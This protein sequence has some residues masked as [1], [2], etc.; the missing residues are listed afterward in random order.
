MSNINISRP[1]YER[2][3]IYFNI[4]DYYE[5]TIV[6]CNSYDTPYDILKALIDYKKN[7][8]SHFIVKD[9]YEFIKYRIS[10]EDG[11]VLI[12]NMCTNNIVYFSETFN[13]DKSI[14]NMLASSNK[15]F[16][17]IVNW[18]RTAPFDGLFTRAKRAI[19]LYLLIKEL[20]EKQ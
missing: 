20:K 8:H 4:E 11:K 16:A 1:C 17:D 15:Y 18:N 3:T 14:S 7:K 2:L 5:Y 6:C 19:T 10:F 9:G 12:T 13:I